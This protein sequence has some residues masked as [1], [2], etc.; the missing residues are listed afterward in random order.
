MQKRRVPRIKSGTENSTNGQLSRDF[1]QTCS[2]IEISSCGRLHPWKTVVIMNENLRPGI[3]LEKR[4]KEGIQ[5]GKNG[6]PQGRTMAGHMAG[7][8]RI[9]EIKDPYGDNQ[10]EEQREKS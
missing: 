3:V 4:T 6:K 7:F 1:A 5:T 2:N 8:L 9:L 10:S